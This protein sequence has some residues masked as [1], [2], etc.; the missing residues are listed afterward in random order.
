M[1]KTP[2]LTLALAAILV[3]SPAW[4]DEHKGEGKAKHGFEKLDTN[5]DGKVTEAEFL[6]VQKARF[7]DMD[8]NKDGAVTKEEGEAARKA[9]GEKMKEYRK[10]KGE[11][12]EKAADAPE[13]A[14]E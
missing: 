2:I 3:S 14:P 11:K 5:G 9:W 8:T 13:K 4:A 7:A 6:D 10:E 12:R 1:K